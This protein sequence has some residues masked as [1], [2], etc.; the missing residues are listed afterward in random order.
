M[1]IE[2]NNTYSNYTGSFMKTNEKKEV[3]KASYIFKY[4]VFS[5]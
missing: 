5:K 4:G 2:I 3:K 1:A